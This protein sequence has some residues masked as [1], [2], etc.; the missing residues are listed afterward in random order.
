MK[1]TNKTPNRTSFHNVTIKTT[2]NK[3]MEAIG[4]PN[5]FENSGKDKVNVEW[6]RETALGHVITIYDYKE[7]RVLGLNEEVEFHLGGQE[8]DHTLTAKREL[9]LYL[10][11]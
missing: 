11:K 2:I 3:L 9:E 10:N 7:Y 8:K 5:Y 4:D 1:K 6:V